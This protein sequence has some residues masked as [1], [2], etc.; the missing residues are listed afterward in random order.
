MRK[1]RISHK[2]SYRGIHPENGCPAELPVNAGPELPVHGEILDKIHEMLAD[3]VR[4]HSKTLLVQF[5]LMHPRQGQWNLDNRGV[6]RFRNAFRTHLVRRELDP[7]IYWVREFDAGS[8]PHYHFACCL[9]GHLTSR[10]HNHLVKAEELWTRALGLTEGR[11]QV[12]Y[13]PHHMILR[14]DRDSFVRAF[15]HVSYLA[16]S[17]GKSTGGNGVRQ[18]AGPRRKRK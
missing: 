12:Q 16:K 1:D 7:R 8:N 10:P 17:R 14:S 15:E 3:Y 9:N 11:G 4:Q 2:P 5:I 18:F 13:I 6:V